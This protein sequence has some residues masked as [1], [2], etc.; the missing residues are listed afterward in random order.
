VLPL[1]GAALNTVTAGRRVTTGLVR[2]QY[3]LG[4][5]GWDSSGPNTG[6]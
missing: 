2:S 4:G 3:L 1:C 6:A 5:L